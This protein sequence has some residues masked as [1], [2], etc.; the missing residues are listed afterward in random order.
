MEIEAYK[1][2]DIPEMIAIW[3]EVVN[4]G[5]AFQIGRAL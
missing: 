3:N 1:E 2:T 5:Q 4:A